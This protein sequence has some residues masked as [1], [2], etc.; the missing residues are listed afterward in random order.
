MQVGLSEQTQHW[1]FCLALGLSHKVCLCQNINI[2]V[3]HEIKARLTRRRIFSTLVELPIF[4]ACISVRLLAC[5]TPLQSMQ[6]KVLVCI[7]QGRN[8]DPGGKLS[9]VS[10]Q[11]SGFRW[12]KCLIYGKCHHA[13]FPYNLYAN[14]PFVGNQDIVWKLNDASK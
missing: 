2:S 3:S 9:K 14:T 7:M 11:I 12:W 10:C 4:K 13:A 5:I 8:K 1:R 6:M